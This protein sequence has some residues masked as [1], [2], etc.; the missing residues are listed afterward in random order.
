MQHSKAYILLNSIQ[1]SSL[2]LCI[3]LLANS[4]AH[5]QSDPILERIEQSFTVE[6]TRKNIRNVGDGTIAQPQVKLKEDIIRL[7][8]A[9]SASSQKIE[10]MQRKKELNG[11][12]ERYYKRP[13][14]LS[15]GVFQSANGTLIQLAHIIP[16]SPD[17][18][19][20]NSQG[21]WP[22]GRFAKAAL[23]RLVRSKTIICSSKNG[24]QKT[25]HHSIEDTCKVA[26]YELG[27]WLVTQG[28]ADSN[29]VDFIKL[30]DE[31]K[32]NGL[33]IWRQ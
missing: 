2:S 3:T 5:S 31:A 21:N 28:W 23:Q 27:K 32:K 9:P 20:Q 8:A 6:K 11:L 25:E 19:C 1:L 16:T 30:K 29:H 24:I 15:A 7:P 33:G 4:P 14:I 10:V 13:L 18:T 22:C 12:E 26:N 17:K